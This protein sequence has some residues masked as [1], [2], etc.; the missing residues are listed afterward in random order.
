M[1]NENFRVTPRDAFKADLRWSA[2]AA[3][4]VSWVFLN[5]RHALGPVFADAAERVVKIPFKADDTVKIEIH[6]LP[7]SSIAPDSVHVL[8]N[9]RPLLK[10]NGVPDAVRYRI[11]HRIKDDPTETLV[12]DKPPLEGQDRFEIACPVK[13]EGRGG[14]WHF[15]RVEAVDPY[16]NESTRQSWTYFVMDL[17]PAP[18][19]LEVVEGSAP[20][21]YDISIQ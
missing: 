6:D 16:G 21:L 4:W 2:P 1:L 3:D 14:V 17:P 18:E 19:S 8:P 13:L 5:G 9:T 12:Y 7:P 10:W 20:G 15:L 11:Y